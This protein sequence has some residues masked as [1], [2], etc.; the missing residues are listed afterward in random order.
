[1]ITS[2]YKV[3]HIRYLGLTAWIWTIHPSFVP[4]AADTGFFSK[5]TPRS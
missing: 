4:M 2:V 3:N 5:L 1:M